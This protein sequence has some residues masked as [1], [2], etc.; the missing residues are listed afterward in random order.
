[1]STTPPII[2]LSNDAVKGSAQLGTPSIVVRSDGT[3]T[4][5]FVELTNGVSLGLVQ[6]IQWELDISGY[7]QCVVT[8]MATPAEIKALMRDT[9]VRVQPMVDVHPWRY[10]WDWYVAK[11]SIWLGAL[12]KVPT[13]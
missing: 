6:N 1:M 8:S 13:P 12:H 10:L 5:T 4:G 2:P 7:A 11:A 3:P 9:T